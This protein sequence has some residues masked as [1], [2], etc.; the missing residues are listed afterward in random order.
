MDLYT[1]EQGQ[2]IGWDYV[3]GSLTITTIFLFKKKKKKEIHIY[4]YIRKFP[5]GRIEIDTFGNRSAQ[6]VGNPLLP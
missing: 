1:L 5:K 4:I 3:R 2:N 6:F